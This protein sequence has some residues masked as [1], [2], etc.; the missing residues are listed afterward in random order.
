M[1]QAADQPPAFQQ[2][3]KTSYKPTENSYIDSFNGRLRDECLKVTQFRVDRGCV[4]QD[5][6]MADPL[7]CA[8][9]PTVHR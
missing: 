9:T 2:G 3:T 4:R 1:K 7:Q 5:R 6:S 8:S